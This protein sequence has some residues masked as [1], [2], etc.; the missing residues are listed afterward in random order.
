MT[1]EDGFTTGFETKVIFS[2]ARPNAYMFAISADAPVYELA[3]GPNSPV[4][5]QVDISALDQ[6]GNAVRGLSV[7]AISDQDG[8]ND[9][10]GTSVFPFVQYFTTKSSGSFPVTYSYRGE[11]GVETLT[12]FA[13]I[14]VPD[15]PRRQ[16]PGH[17]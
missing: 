15:R 3:R 6:Y 8:G 13:A 10:T 5:S 11:P 17:A 12:A 1:A 2:D 4:G 16:R 7:N 14:P 9:A